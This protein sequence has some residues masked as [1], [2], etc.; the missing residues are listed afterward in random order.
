MGT[1]IPGEDGLSPE[2]TKL[3]KALAKDPKSKLFMPLAEEYVK[4]GML[5]DAVAVL[6]NGL[7]HYPTFVTARVAL[8]RLYFQL[9]NGAKARTMLEE[10]TKLSPENLLAHKTLARVY[11]R[12]GAVD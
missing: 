11:E 9:E 6:E 1:L 5:E 12:A 2:I 7:K 10:A 8:G 3:T 4:I